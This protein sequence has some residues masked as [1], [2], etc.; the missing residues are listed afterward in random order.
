MIFKQKMKPIFFFLIFI[1]S[2]AN[3]QNFETVFEKSNGLETA[4][5]EQTITFYKNLANK[6]PEIKIQEIGLTDSGKPLH[7]VTFNTSENSNLNASK[8]TI[9]I[10]NGIHPGEPDGIDA[11]MILLRDIMIEPS[12]LLMVK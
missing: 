3:A 12:K 9:L 4:T 7:L 10:N 2:F 6:Y 5:Y 1:F 8:N 11:S